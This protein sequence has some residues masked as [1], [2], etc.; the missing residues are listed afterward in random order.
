MAESN[1]TQAPVDSGWRCAKCG[2]N[3]T[4]LMKPPCPE[5]G[6]F[7]RVSFSPKKVSLGVILLVLNLL[8]IPLVL[9]IL[10]P[11]P[12]QQPT[13]GWFPWPPFWGLVGMCVVIPLQV[14][15]PLCALVA[16]AA[17]KN[18]TA[19]RTWLWVGAVGPALITA[20]S[21]LALKWRV[22]Y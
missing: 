4:G 21:F 8:S 7:H 2:Y 13:F 19:T 14:I 15:L 9:F 12:R 16:F 1:Q 18:E 10:S 17:R 6:S 20:L 3:L 5:C 22:H 11:L